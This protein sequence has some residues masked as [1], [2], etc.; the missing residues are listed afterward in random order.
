MNAFRMTRD[1]T[2]D[3]QYLRTCA[4]Y[5]LLKSRRIDKAGAVALQGRR[6]R[7]QE[8]STGRNAPPQGYLTKTIEIWLA[9]PLSERGRAAAAAWRSVALRQ[10]LGARSRDGT[11][12]NRAA[13][14]RATHSH[15][16][17]RGVGLSEKPHRHRAYAPRRGSGKNEG[18]RPMSATQQERMQA[19][20]TPRAQARAAG[21]LDGLYG[22][23]TRRLMQ[24]PDHRFAYAAG[25]RDGTR[26][27]EEAM[28]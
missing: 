14:S 26:A 5:R 2:L 20:R 10:R 16:S 3:R 9:G 4:I 8:T 1:R 21:Y 22:I 25:H 23:E 28:T 6:Y 19:A 12:S 18:V 24:P 17:I 7:A 13:L 11:A 15:R 27:R